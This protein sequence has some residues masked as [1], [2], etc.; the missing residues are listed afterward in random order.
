MSPGPVHLETVGAQWLPQFSPTAIQR[1]PG[2]L[3]AQELLAQEGSLYPTILTDR[4]G[5]GG[6]VAVTGGGRVSHE[7]LTELQ[8]SQA[9][10]DPRPG[11]GFKRPYPAVSGSWCDSSV[12]TGPKGNRYVSVSPS[13]RGFGSPPQAGRGGVSPPVPL[14]ARVPVQAS[15]AGLGL[16]SPEST[17][18]PGRPPLQPQCL[19]TPPHRAAARGGLPLSCGAPLPVS[20]HGELDPGAAGP[21][22][23]AGA[24]GPSMRAGPWT[25]Q[26]RK[27]QRHRAEDPGPASPRVSQPSTRSLESLLPA[28]LG[29]ANPRSV[30]PF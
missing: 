27:R 7:S 16:S 5:R 14:P 17:T 3:P 20:G 6:R 21:E 9:T 24:R 10:V 1:E 13:C 11:T 22:Q 18:N 12:E 8:F 28:A 25:S 2:C 19:G 26:D 30:L 29:M 15:E 23:A 4:R